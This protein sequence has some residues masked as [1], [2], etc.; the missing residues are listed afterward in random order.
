MLGY[1]PDGPN[2]YG[3]V[4][5]SVRSLP[6]VTVTLQAPVAVAVLLSP[7]AAMAKASSPVAVAVLLSPK[8]AKAV[9]PSPV[10]V[11][12]FPE[13]PAAVP[14]AA[15]A[16]S[17]LA[18]ATFAAPS[19]TVDEQVAVPSWTLSTPLTDTHRFGTPCAEATP[20]VAAIS[21]ATNPTI[22]KTLL[23][24]IHRLS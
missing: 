16:P 24:P 19:L 9:A 4:H 7:K 3:P 23:I 18:R 17:P 15:N 6:P 13:S 21:A 2:S 12:R 10:A 20:T 14:A 5:E 8:V 1:V 11:A 22:T